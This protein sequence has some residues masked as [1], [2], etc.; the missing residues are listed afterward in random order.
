MMSKNL[1]VVIAHWDAEGTVKQHLLESVQQLS[2]LGARIVFVSTRLSEPMRAKLEEQCTVIVRENR[3]WDIYSY[4]EGVAKLDLA[5]LDQLLIFN[6]SLIFFEPH[7][8]GVLLDEGRGLGDLVG[9][10]QSSEYCP[11]L[12]S[13]Y[14]QFN[15]KAIIGS[16]AFTD[17]WAQVEALEEQKQVITAYELTMGKWFSD[18][19]FSLGTLYQRTAATRIRGFA[20]AILS[21]KINLA[22]LT[23]D[24]FSFDLGLIN[25]LNPTFFEWDELFLQHRVAK[26]KLL[27]R[28]EFNLAEFYALLQAHTVSRD[29]L[30]D[31]F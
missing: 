26:E 25:Q 30:S 28:R 2:A 13:Y 16:V 12:Q 4:K 5:Q 7:R 19:G 24:Q 3:G 11:H 22:G 1:G 29:Y 27:T 6:S 8:H 31:Y 23:S 9:M 18:R 17:W 10:T 21:Q 14:F 15:G 20:R